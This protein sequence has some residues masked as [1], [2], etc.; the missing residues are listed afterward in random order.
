MGALPFLTVT[1]GVDVAQTF[2]EAV[3]QAQYAYGHAGYSGS[4]AEKE[5]YVVIEATPMTEDVAKSMAE[6]L[7][8]ADDARI[9]APRGPA[10]AIA[11]TNGAEHTGWL[12]F[13]WAPS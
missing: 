3:E 2:C 7:I 8:N 12:F 9:A 10:G 5:S 11:V 13:G 4:L 1:D 6:R